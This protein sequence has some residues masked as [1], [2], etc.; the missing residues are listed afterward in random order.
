MM[1]PNCDGWS[2]MTAPASSSALHF[3]SAVPSPR[4]RHA[5]LWP[6]ISPSTAQR[7]ATSAAIG[8]ALVRF[9]TLRER[10]RRT[11]GSAPACDTPWSTRP[12]PPRPYRR[13]RRPAR[14][15]P[16]ARRAR[17]RGGRRRGQFPRR[18]RRPCQC[19]GSAQCQLASETPRSRSS[20]S[21]TLQRPQQARARRTTTAGSQ[22]GIVPAAR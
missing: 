7:P 6:M 4:P 22:Y 18:R 11:S 10:G 16:C 15:L 20:A 5:P 9:S 17:R 2:A 19:T 21:L 13:S 12:P 3:C 14:C 1:D 8:L